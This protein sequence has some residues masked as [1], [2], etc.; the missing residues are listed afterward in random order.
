VIF[1]LH[2]EH[3]PAGIAKSRQQFARLIDMA[4]KHHGSFFLTYHR[5]A[6][7]EQVLACYPRLPAFMRHKQRYDPQGRFQ[8]EWY[9]HYERQF[10]I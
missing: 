2:T 8:S 7:P 6:T 1:N 9:R 10:S 4:I 3:T 5:Y